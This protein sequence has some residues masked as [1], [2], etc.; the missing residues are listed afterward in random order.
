MAKKKHNAAKTGFKELSTK[1]NYGRI[2]TNSVQE[3]KIIFQA[4]SQEPVIH[5]KRI[6][7][8]IVLKN[9]LMLM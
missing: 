1:S 7:K 3:S 8:S 5:F 2:D 4:E 9:K 6:E